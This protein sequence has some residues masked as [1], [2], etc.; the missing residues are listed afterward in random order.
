[1]PEDN[2]IFQPATR[3]AALLRARELSPVDLTRRYLSH[4]ERHNPAIKAFVTVTA[5]IAL[6]QARQAEAEMAAGKNR[7]PLHGIPYALKR[8]FATKGIATTT[9]KFGDQDWIP[10]YESTVTRRLRRAGAILLGGLNLIESPPWGRADS[11]PG[12]A[13]NPWDLNYSPSGSSSGSAAAI[14]AGMAPLTMGTDSNGS[15][16]RPA[17]S[18]GVS[19]LKPT[20]GRVSRYGVATVNGILDHAGPLGRTVADV[21]MLLEVIAGAD[22][23]DEESANVPVPY[24]SAALGRPIQGLRIG[25]PTNYFFENVQPEVD[26][27]LRAAL[28]VLE[29]EGVEL[30]DVFVEDAESGGVAGVISGYGLSPFDPQSGK[31]RRA[32][33]DPQYF[34]VEKLDFYFLGDYAA[35][36][37]MRIR[38]IQE[39][40]RVF[41]CCDVLMLPAGNPAPP[42]SQEFFNAWES[43]GPPPP[44]DPDVFDI[45]NF[46]GIPALVLPCGFTAG[47]P[48]L[49][50][51]VQFCAKPFNEV[52]LFR[53]GHAYQQLTDWH[54]RTPPS[55]SV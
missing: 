14:A 51:G 46:T 27:A 36:L 10:E 28:R 39:M 32:P 6:E 31:T 8:V 37:Q 1:M 30:V 20:F 26:K 24:Y 43:S 22:P 55:L 48:V 42:F 5:D 25:I 12:Y 29:D 3:L 19:G 44:R 4:I 7:G 49:P 50:I 35:A 40:H 17:Q 34:Y 45:A 15:I 11:V 21:A 41:Q 23:L 18:C 52:A 54:T 33:L 2:L 9:G 13:R 47:P 53:V 38:L 16:R